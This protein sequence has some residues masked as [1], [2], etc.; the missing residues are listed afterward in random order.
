MTISS[1]V[2]VEK[3]SFENNQFS[4]R[5]TWISY[6]FLIE[7]GS[8]RYHCE[9]N[10]QVK[11]YLKFRKSLLNQWFTFCATVLSGR[12][13]WS[14][15]LSCLNSML[16][17]S[18]AAEITRNTEVKSSSDIP[19][20]FKTKYLIIFVYRFIRNINTGIHVKNMNELR[21]NLKNLSRGSNMVGFT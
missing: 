13:A 4:K 1:F 8:K 12:V 20:T 19:I 7:Q 5:I 16:P 17:K 11:G 3:S 10:M 14:V 15:F 9:S 6:S 18:R 2:Y 21:P